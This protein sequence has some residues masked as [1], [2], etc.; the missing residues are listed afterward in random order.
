[1]SHSTRMPAVF[2]GNGNPMNAIECNRYTE[3]WRAF[4]SSIPKPKAVLAISAH[5]YIN[6]TAALATPI[7]KTIHDFYGFP[8]ELYEVD[9]PAPGDPELAVALKDLVT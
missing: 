2:F 3:A 9:Y 7:P 1:M 5:W 8:Q 4:G 6:A